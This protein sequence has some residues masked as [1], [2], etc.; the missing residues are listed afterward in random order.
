MKFENLQLSWPIGRRLTLAVLFLILFWFGGEWIIIRSAVS[1]HLLTPSVGSGHRQMD[2]VI[3][4]LDVYLATYGEVDCFFIG[5]SLT[6][7]GVDPE[8]FESTWETKTGEAIHCFNFGLLGSTTSTHTQLVQILA[9]KYQPEMIIYGVNPRL[10]DVDLTEGSYEAFYATPWVK[11]NSGEFS[12][13]GALLEISPLYRQIMAY[14]NWAQPHYLEEQAK[15][16]GITDWGFFPEIQIYDGSMNFE[17]GLAVML[18]EYDLSSKYLGSL[19]TIITYLETKNIELVLVEMPVN[20]NYYLFFEQGEADYLL[21]YEE[22]ARVANIAGIPFIETHSD[23]L[24][25]AQGWY[26]FYH[27]NSTGAEMFSGWLA[28]QIVA[29]EDQ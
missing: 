27:M 13:S 1:E 24:I 4:R 11:Y 10:F 21:F 2:I 3:A 6:V 29:G 9:E 5:S 7:R 26:D 28:E 23:Q 12:I 25:P 18:L 20:D 17:S 22:V 15:W 8:I 16:D 14:R 19:Q